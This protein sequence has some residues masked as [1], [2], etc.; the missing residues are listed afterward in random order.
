MRNQLKQ[1]TDI[2][3]HIKRSY[4]TYAYSTI[5]SRLIYTLYKRNN[6][7]KK[8]S[9]IVPTIGNSCLYKMLTKYLPEQTHENWEALVWSDGPN[10]DAE[11]MTMAA[12][13]HD[14]RIEYYALEKHTGLWGH[15]QTRAGILQASGEFIV[16]MND[17]NV[18]Y[19]NYLHTLLYGFAYQDIAFTYAPVIFKGEARKNYS[20]VLIDNYIIPQK[21]IASFSNNI[22]CMCFMVRTNIANEFIHYWNNTYSADFHFI[23]EIAHN[24]IHTFVDSIIG[25]KW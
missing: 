21:N 11:E 20:S 9:I 18:P 1:I 6:Y 10:K 2:Y 14:N 5:D 16:R 17:D 7:N 23:N 22:D 13:N 12:A 25:E 15:P 24:R 4:N 19:N 8:V 3:Y